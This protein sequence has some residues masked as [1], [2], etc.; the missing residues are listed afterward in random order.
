[1]TATADDL[2]KLGNTSF[3]ANEFPQ[4]IEH[5]TNAIALD[6]N[7]HVLYSNRSAAYASLKDYKLALE[8]AEKTVELKSDWAKGYSRK[9][10]ALYGLENYDEAVAVYEKGLALDPENALLKRGLEDVKNAMMVSLTFN[11][12]PAKCQSFRK[13][14]RT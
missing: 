1:M 3:Q 8:D 11:P 13:A 4:A 9:G 2:K 5:F 10:A 6:E 12:L 7:N 14:F